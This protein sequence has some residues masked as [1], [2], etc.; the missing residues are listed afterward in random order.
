MH[1]DYFGLVP[2]GED[3]QLHKMLEIYGKI[4]NS[5]EDSMKYQNFNA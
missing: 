3:C 5:Y 2:F 1:A 4:T